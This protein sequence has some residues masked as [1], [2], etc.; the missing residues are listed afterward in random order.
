MLLW[1]L[2]LLGCK[3]A[4]EEVTCDTCA[5]AG[6]IC[7]QHVDAMP[8]WVRC[9]PVPTECGEA[10]DCADNTCLLDAYALCEPGY[11]GSTCSTEVRPELTCY[12]ESP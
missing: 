1:C 7:V 12:A 3:D 11:E 5:E 2:V 10:L 4:D 9:A 6:E 8:P